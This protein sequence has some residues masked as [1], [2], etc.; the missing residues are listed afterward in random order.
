VRQILRSLTEI[1][2]PDPDI[3][4]RLHPENI[5]VP[6]DWFNPGT[7]VMVDGK[8]SWQGW[9]RVVRENCIE[10]L[11]GGLVDY[12]FGESL[13]D[14]SRTWS[15]RLRAIGQLLWGLLRGSFDLPA[16]WNI[17]GQERSLIEI[18]AWDLE[19]L[20]I[21][22]FTLSILQNC[23]LPRSRET[24]LLVQFPSLFGNLTGQ[25]ADDTEFDLPILSPKQFLERLAKSQEVLEHS[26]ITVLEHEPRQLIPVRIHQLAAFDDGTAIEP[27]M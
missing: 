14:G 19:R 17:R 1:D 8:I 5:L 4:D 2:G 6:S 9:R 21:S 3:L 27:E 25:A 12:R 22:S 23:L 24:S 16:P 7:G 20:P 18:V 10:V 26:Q 11:P 15:G 13:K